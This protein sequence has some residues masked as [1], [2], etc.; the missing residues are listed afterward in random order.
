MASGDGVEFVKRLSEITGADVTASNDLTGNAALGGD[1]DLEVQT[2]A[3]AA[4]EVLDPVGMANYQGTLAVI[5]V[6]NNN[7]SGSGSLRQAIIDANKNSGLDVIDLSAIAGQTITLL[8]S[9]PTVTDSLFIDGVESNKIVLDG[10]G[11]YQ[12]IGVNTTDSNAVVTFSGIKFYRGLAKGGDGNDGGGGGLGAGGA[13]VAYKGNVSVDRSEFDTNKAQGGNGASKGAKGG[14]FAGVGDSS[15][16]GGVFNQGSQLTSDLNLPLGVATIVFGGAPNGNLVAQSGSSGGNGS[17]GSGGGGGSGGAGTSYNGN[18]GSTVPD[19]NIDKA[20]NGGA[21]GAG[22]FGAGGGGGGGG[23]FDVD[24]LITTGIS[25]EQ[26]IGGNG[27]AGG[28]K[29]GNGASGTGG[30]STGASGGQ[31]GGGGALGGAIFAHWNAGLTITNST[32]TN[33]SVQAGTGANSG[34]AADNSVAGIYDS[35]SGKYINTGFD[36]VTISQ[37]VYKPNNDSSRTSPSTVSIPTI[38]LSNPLASEDSAKA[39]FTVD[40]TGTIP[41]NGIPLYYIIRQGANTSSADYNDPNTANQILLTQNGQKLELNIIDDDL[42]EPNQETLTVE[43]LPSPAYS[44]VDNKYVSTVAIADN[45]PVIGL[46]LLQNGA[47]GETLADGTVGKPHGL[48]QL[49]FDKAAPK[50][51]TLYF[52]AP[53][54]GVVDSTNTANRGSIANPDKTADYRLY[55]R[56]KSDSVDIRNYFLTNTLD[57]NQIVVSK[58]TGTGDKEIYVGVEVFNDEIFESTE[59]FDLSL[60]ADP[61]GVDI[62]YRIDSA[63]TKTTMAIA[64]NDPIISITKVVNP[65]EGFG[66]GSTLVGLGS[67]LQLEKD[68]NVEIAASTSLDLTKNNQFTLEFWTSIDKLAA[69]SYRLI[70][71]A[72]GSLDI[73]VNSAGKIV[74]SIQNGTLGKISLES[75]DTVTLDTWTHVA[76]SFDGE[77]FNLFINGQ[78]I[79]FDNGSD[80]RLI[81]GDS[82]F[83]GSAA[84]PDKNKPV[85]TFLGMVDEVRLWN[86]A[87]TQEQIQQNLLTNYKGDEQG[88]V[89]YWQLDDNVNDASVNGNNGKLTSI[90]GLNGQYFNDANPP[91]GKPIFNSTPVLSRVDPKLDFNYSDSPGPGVNADNFSAKWTGYILA[92]KT[93][94]YTF[95]LI[96]DDGVRMRLNNQLIVNRWIDSDAK[97]PDDGNLSVAM[98]AGK[99]YPVALDYYENKVKAELHLLWSATDSDGKQFKNDEVVGTEN[100]RASVDF[101]ENPSPQLGYI[102]IQ[103]TDIN[104]NPL[105]IAQGNGLWVRYNITGG[106]ATRLP[107]PDANGSITAGNFDYYNSQFQ[108]SSTD[109]LT[110]FDG[111]VIAKGESTAR[112]YFGAVSDAIVEG[113]EKISVEIIPYNIDPKPTTLDDSANK[114]K[115]LSKYGLRDS[116]GA[117]VGSLK[118]DILIQDSL[119]YKAGFFVLGA[120]NRLIGAFRDGT[121]TS[122]DNI[123]PDVSNSATVLLRPS[124]QPTGTGTVSLTLTASGQT[125]SWDDTNWETAKSLTLSNLS[126]T[127][128]KLSTTI[129][130]SDSKYSGMPDFNLTLGTPREDYLLL[131]ESPLSDKQKP[132]IPQVSLLVSDRLIEN[133]PDIPANVIIRLSDPAPVGGLKLYLKVTGGTAKLGEDYTVKADLAPSVTPEVS[134]GVITTSEIN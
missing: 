70:G 127:S 122:F 34:T 59:K 65:S 30:T 68:K 31:G 69:D 33:N 14:A 95:K 7:D 57:S 21:G 75:L 67:A 12:I 60:L 41:P 125:L 26:G 36:N 13:I 132:V 85:T 103:S 43:L 94:S 120:N 115:D 63:N 101:V 27:G 17:F 96:A 56:Y 11:K 61:K 18:L 42:Y 91:S 35:G 29:A 79:K 90:Q 100:L 93:G 81:K 121:Y 6:T 55:W 62:N 72:N 64:D 99:L 76:T 87:R 10:Q 47:E 16:G 71:F 25:V 86:V 89:G 40:V 44:R 80:R 3:I 5:T 74:A 107:R 38:A 46:K 78:Q 92:P 28:F 1:W 58:G 113:D 2:G 116:T 82:L 110:R 8:S 83:I 37:A 49:T 52:A 109:P 9:L 111:V 129:T 88:L 130:S 126:G 104:G 15:Q 51:F 73:S 50:D 131:A 54:I 112:I 84:N 23:G 119:R 22:G 53:A 4:S 32:F 39:V 77:T 123:Q 97:I 24:D 105:P 108:V 20:G 98:E 102:E 45:E 106:N 66:Y 117:I 114:N 128:F 124:S 19:A 134:P 133:Q 48:F 118:Q